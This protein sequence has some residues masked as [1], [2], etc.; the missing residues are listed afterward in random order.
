MNT[1]ERIKQ[2]CKE[3]KIPIS[4]LE[5]D[6]GFSNGYIGQ[7]R[8]GTVPDD[9]LLIISKYLNVSIEYL[10]GSDAYES[11]TLYERYCNIRD[12]KGLK[13]ADVAKLSCVTKS[14]F[15]DW[16]KGLYKPKREK[17]IKIADA[18]GVSIEYLMDDGKAVLN[19]SNIYLSDKEKEVL[20][21]YRNADNAQKE[22]INR[23]LSYFN[24]IRK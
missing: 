22:I 1:V 8:K 4:K 3:R 19:P 20:T 18:L 11:T 24:N 17:L 7:L 15:S 10:L 16:K 23:L 12:E 2:I 6:C 14:T 13:D 5:R 9:R 21:A